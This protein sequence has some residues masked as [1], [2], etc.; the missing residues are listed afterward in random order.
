MEGR[1]SRDTV[2]GARLHEYIPEFSE[3]IF[4]SVFGFSRPKEK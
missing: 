1:K 4:Y 2:P 3:R